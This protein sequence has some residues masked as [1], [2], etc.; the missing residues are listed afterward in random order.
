MVL[1]W[2][3]SIIPPSFLGRLC[4][5]RAAAMRLCC[6]TRNQSWH[7][8]AIESCF[9]FSIHSGWPLDLARY[10]VGWTFVE[11]HICLGK[12]IN[13]PE[14]RIIL[15]TSSNISQSAS[16]FLWKQNG[17]VWAS[18]HNYRDYQNLTMDADP[19]CMITCLSQRANDR[20]WRKSSEGQL[21]YR[22][23]QG[24]LSLSYLFGSA[25]NIGLTIMTTSRRTYPLSIL[26]RHSKR[27]NEN[28]FVFLLALCSFLLSNLSFIAKK[29]LL[30]IRKEDKPSTSRIIWSPVSKD[31]ITYLRQAKAAN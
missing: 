31:C 12:K 8:L 28:L 10:Q 21:T 29:L 22:V 4:T 18:D 5:L 14:R 11:P 6:Q 27:Q 16:L 2:L 23:N 30:I 15:I 1:N 7:Q 26:S 19:Y 9:K 13:R 17:S 3:L 24:A 20:R 25:L